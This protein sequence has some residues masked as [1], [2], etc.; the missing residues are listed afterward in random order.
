ML[1]G[2]F[3]GM[4]VCVRGCIVLSTTNLWCQQHW[5]RG[6]HRDRGCDCG[7]GRVSSRPSSCGRCETR[8][9]GEV[10]SVLVGVRAG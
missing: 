4:L 2:E 8:L 6:C 5:R 10:I 1:N 3:V 7:C 9:V